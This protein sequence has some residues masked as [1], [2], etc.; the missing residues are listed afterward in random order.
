[1]HWI[2]LLVLEMIKSMQVDVQVKKKW[3]QYAQ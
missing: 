1:M 3:E 2:I